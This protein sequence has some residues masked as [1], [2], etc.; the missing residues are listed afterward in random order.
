MQVR[1]ALR[2]G[3]AGSTSVARDLVAAD[4]GL[5]RPVSTS[6]WA[7]TIFSS[8]KLRSMTA[9]IRPAAAMSINRR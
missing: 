3:F 6:R 9:R 8:G 5:R 4:E 1:D 7:S 2:L